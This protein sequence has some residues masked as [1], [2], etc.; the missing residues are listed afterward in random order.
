MMPKPEGLIIDCSEMEG[1]GGGRYP[2][3]M[4]MGGKIKYVSDDAGG[5]A[6]AFSDMI[7]EGE[8]PEGLWIAGM[9]D[10]IDT[11]EQTFQIY[12]TL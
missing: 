1:S 6:D 5:I 10:N 3:Y 8:M 7:S 12:N 2:A 9:I 4:V 11:D